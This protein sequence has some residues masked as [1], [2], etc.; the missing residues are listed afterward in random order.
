MS[1]PRTDADR[2]KAREMAYRVAEF[3][4]D[5][6]AALVE[7]EFTNTADRREILGRSAPVVMDMALKG[8]FR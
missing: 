7:E 2:A 3:L 8:I 4:A 6:N 5:L 1:R